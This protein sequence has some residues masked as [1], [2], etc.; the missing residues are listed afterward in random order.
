VLNYLLNY[1]L[2]SVCFDV[3]DNRSEQSAQLSAMRRIARAKLAI[4][5]RHA[6]VRRCAFVRSGSCFA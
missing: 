6:H 3:S 5:M 1:H 2:L 4:V